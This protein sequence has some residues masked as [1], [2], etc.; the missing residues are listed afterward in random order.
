MAWYH[1]L[2]WHWPLNASDFYGLASTSFM[3]VCHGASASSL[4]AQL[5]LL[6]ICSQ[7]VAEN[8]LQFNRS[9]SSTPLKADLWGQTHA[10]KLPAQRRHDRLWRGASENAAWPHWK[11]ANA[12]VRGAVVIYRLPAPA[13]PLEHQTGHQE[14]TLVSRKVTLFLWGPTVRPCSRALYRNTSWPEHMGSN[15]V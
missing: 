14:E 11:H 8:E 13:A 2:Y 5:V 7:P 4:S 6:D 9:R 3:H 10:W 1:C 15:L 12:R